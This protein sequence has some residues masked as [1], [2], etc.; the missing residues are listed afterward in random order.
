MKKAG[1]IWRG[2]TDAQ[3][4]A[5]ERLPNS[6]WWLQLSGSAD[7]ADTS[8]LPQGLGLMSPFLGVFQ[9]K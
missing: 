8:E 7:R 1:D 4:K 3:K 5:S 9:T 2:L 6:C